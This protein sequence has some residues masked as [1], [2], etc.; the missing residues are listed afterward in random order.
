MINIREKHNNNEIYFESEII[1]NKKTICSNEIYYRSCVK[2][3]DGFTYLMLYDPNM[4]PISDVFGFLN[5][6]TA[7]QS[8]NTRIKSLQALKLLYCYQ[9]I[10]SKELENFTLSDIN[11]LKS[12]LRGISPKGQYISF[13]LSSIRNSETINGYLSVYRRYLNYLGKN[14]MALNKKSSKTTLVSLPYSEVDYKVDRFSSNE[15]TPKK[16]IEVPRYISVEKFQKIINLV[17]DKYTAREEILIRLMFQ[18]GLRLGECLGATADDLVMEQID[19]VF[20]PILYIRNR[21]SDKPYQHAKT[22]MK[23]IDKKQYKSKEYKTKGYG[24]QYIVVPEDLYNLINDYIEDVHVTAREKKHENY[25]ASTIADRI[26]NSEEYEDDNYYIFINSL[27][28]PISATSWNNIL[29]EIFIACEIPIDKRIREH[30]LNHKLRHGFAM[31]NV[32]YLGCKELELKERMRHNSLQ[33]VACYFKPTTSDAIKV[34]TDF[35]KSLY[36]V[37]PELKRGDEY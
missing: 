36:E 21:V 2:D 34:K 24:Y 23:V 12:F 16:V 5:F 31:F 32:Q 15:K 8:I 7:S 13:E 6:D 20:V 9:A 29:R 4:E 1:E 37:I 35:T 11:G 30:N 28:R 17:R 14:N 19:N 18:C 22:C 33:S 26:R 25:Y 3:K 27:G 10:I